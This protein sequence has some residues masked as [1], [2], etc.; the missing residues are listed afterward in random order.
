MQ[1]HNSNNNNNNNTQ[2]QSFICN[3]NIE[4]VDRS[5]YLRSK[6]EKKCQSRVFY[7]YQHQNRDGREKNDRP[8]RHLEL[9]QEH[10]G[11]AKDKI[12]DVCCKK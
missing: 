11:P 1:Q 6:I 9:R 3:K 8:Y 2:G 4:C 5:K 10:R 12:D 7:G